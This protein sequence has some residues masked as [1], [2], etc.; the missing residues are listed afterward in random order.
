MRTSWID[1]RRI[2]STA[3]AIVVVVVLSGCVLSQTGP[4][5]VVADVTADLTGTLRSTATGQTQYWFEYGTSIAYGASSAHT[6]VAVFAGGVPIDVS[7]VVG[8]LT[9]GTVYHYRLCNDAVADAA[10]AP[11]CGAD[12]TVTTS[13]GRVSVTGSA[14]VD[15][16]IL[17]FF[18]YDEATYSLDAA[19]DSPDLGYLDGS[20]L[21][22]HKVFFKSDVQ[23][24]T[25]GGGPI[26][27]LRVAGD[28]ATVG[29]G[30]TGLLVIEDNGPR[31]PNGPGD[32]FSDTS[33]PAGAPCPVPSVALL[34]P[35]PDRG[36]FTV[37]GG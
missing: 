15:T 35:T 21:V 9:A 7:T 33:R 37:N 3:I 30:A 22:E 26:E 10:T 24:D 25:F 11:S 29:Y 17:E 23:S 6:T 5:R 32:N 20:V 4:A 19:A 1:R 8:G 27:C 16:P 12:T 18:S 28:L 14:T 13:V 2:G 36:D 34:G 31:P